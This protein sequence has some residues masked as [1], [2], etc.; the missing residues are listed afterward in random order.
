MTSREHVTSRDALSARFVL[1]SHVKSAA[2]AGVA[3]IRV[4]PGHAAVVIVIYCNFSYKINHIMIVAYVWNRE[5]YFVIQCTEK[6][7]AELK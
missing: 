3:Q 1:R 4:R 6:K 2:L 5:F 7:S